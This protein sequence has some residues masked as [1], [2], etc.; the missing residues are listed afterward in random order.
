MNKFYLILLLNLVFINGCSTVGSTVTE[1]NNNDQADINADNLNSLLTDTVLQSTLEILQASEPVTQAS[2]EQQL[3]QYLNQTEEP[4]ESNNVWDT[5]PQM[6]QFSDISNQ[7]IVSQEKWFLKHKKHLEAISRRAEP[8]LYF[9]SEEVR[10]RNMPGEIVLLPIIESSFRTSAYSGM[11]ASGLWQFLPSTGRAFGLKQNWWYDGRLD[12]YHSTLAALTYLQQLHK[13]YKGDWLLA[14]AAYNAGSGN[15]NKAIRKNLKKGKP[16]DY[17]SLSLPR[18]TYKYIPKLIA[19]ARVIRDREQH[20]ISLTPISNSPRLILVNTESQIDLAVVADMAE[21]SLKDMRAYNPAFKQ[22]A[23]D[24]DGPHHL[25]IPIDKAAA[26]EEKLA[27]LDKKHRVQ[28]YRHKIRSGESLS[29]IAHRYKISISALKTANRLK[30]NRIRAGKYLMV[31]IN[32]QTGK[33]LRVAKTAPGKTPV[34][35]GKAGMQ[36]YT[37]RK[38]DSFWLIARRFN[39]SHRKLAAING[40]SSGDTLSIG[41]QLQVAVQDPA[42]LNN[43]KKQA[44]SY[45]VRSGDSLYTIS[46]QFNVSIND[47]QRWNAL[48]LKKYLQPGQQLKVFI[49]KSSQT[50]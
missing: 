45:K 9:I 3:Q 31:P 14:L 46:R 10:K 12:V 44:I 25:F 17:W 1:N 34:T 18:E 27:A 21:I 24:P 16:V 7:R 26:F 36:H 33:P 29:V 28:W 8:F 47:L 6:Y 41:Q 32:G 5:L 19:I 38:G 37:V 30:N 50:I 4:T 11:K 39:M 20:N 40:L 13:Y 48:S 49:N 2:V 23:T 15:I 22:W 42:E 43:G 35:T